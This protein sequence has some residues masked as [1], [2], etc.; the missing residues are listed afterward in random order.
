MKTIVILT[1]AGISAESGLQTFRD[2]DGL[3]EGFRVEEVATPQAWQAD[4][5]KV[6]DFYN[7]RRK[8]VLEAR[9]NAGFEA[10][11]QQGK[12]AVLG[13]TGE[14]GAF[15]Q[16]CHGFVADLEAFQD[17]RCPFFHD[18]EASGKLH[19]VGE[20]VKAVLLE[21]LGGKTIRK[22]IQRRARFAGQMNGRAKQVVQ[23]VVTSLTTPPARR[24][25]SAPDRCPHGLFPENVPLFRCPGVAGGI[26]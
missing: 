8:A 6:Q 12:V 18:A 24:A 26:S 21:T 3:W 10:V 2:A 7:Q 15:D 11:L 14:Q 17:D 1:G 4:P 13:F 25:V 16:R 22:E 20:L 23:C 19:E 5:H 9:P